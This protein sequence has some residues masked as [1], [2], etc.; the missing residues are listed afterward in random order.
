M[1]QPKAIGKGTVNYLLETSRLDYF[2]KGGNP[3]GKFLGSGADILFGQSERPVKHEELRA[4]LEGLH[5][6]TGASLVQKQ[7]DKDRQLG[8][9]VVV[10]PPK[11]L[12][13]LWSQLDE[14]R[15]R[16]LLEED[17]EAMKTTLRYVED[18]HIY[19]RRGKDGTRLERGKPVVAGFRHF[20]SRAGDPLIHTHLLISNLCFRA[21]GSTGTILSKPFYD[22]QKLFGAIYRAELAS[23]LEK[24]L[25]VRCT[26]AK[27]GWSFTFEGHSEALDQEF[28][29]RS[30]QINSKLRTHGSPA[31]REAAA[32]ETRTEKDE[33]PLGEKLAEWKKTGVAHG[34][35]PEQVMGRLPRVHSE[36]HRFA[37]AWK[38][39][40]RSVT[41]QKSHFTEHE[42]LEQVA[43]QAQGLGL[44]ANDFVGR[45]QRALANSRELIALGELKGFARYTTKSVFR[46]EQR[47]IRSVGKLNATRHGV[48]G[49]HILN[50]LRKYEDARSAVVSEVRHHVSQLINAAKKVPTEKIQR[51][52]LK[53]RSAWVPDVEQRQAI[54]ALTKKGSGIRALEGWAGT[55][56]TS[57][58]RVVNEIYQKRGYTVI[59]VT[60]AGKAAEELQAHSGIA[61]C[62]IETLKLKM[63]PTLAFQAK[64]HAKQIPDVLFGKI[65]SP[66]GV[67]PFKFTKKSVLVIDEVS[68]VETRDLTQLIRAAQRAGAM[69]I[70]AGDYRQLPAIGRG[71]GGEFIANQ[72]KKIVV[73]RIRRQQDERDREAIK[74]LGRGEA[75][76]ALKNLADRGKI[77][78][79]KNW[80]EAKA[81]LVADWMTR[82]KGNRKDAQIYVSG[83]EDRKDINQRC[84]AARLESGELKGH[85]AKCGE[86][87]FYQGDR[88]IFRENSRS[89]GVRNGKLGT[90]RGIL[91]TR[92]L[93]IA[94]VKLDSGKNVLVPLSSY[95][96][97]DHGYAVTA[98]VGQGGTNRNGYHLLGGG[99]GVAR[100]MGYVQLS[101]HKENI[102]IYTDRAHAGP[103][104]SRLAKML[105]QSR[106]K[107]LA[108]EVKRQVEEERGKV[109][110]HKSHSF[111]EELSL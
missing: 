89:I 15:Q 92:V 63:K 54:R 53:E 19:T 43:I 99:N 76:K 27:D 68:M 13:T 67:K 111:G 65:K 25:N 35:T 37:Q 64:Y 39:A 88:V 58:L 77:Q 83:N 100:E 7:K 61:S 110:L 48:G 86:N 93:P 1:W 78:V 108:H 44:G 106:K 14:E 36:S 34:Y 21:D 38:A 70:T 8:T 90:I 69:V 32:N 51:E 5:P 33:R 28:S 12:A 17:W 47:L 94:L 72:V 73:S 41:E 71:G 103:D 22:F 57:I 9:Q 62:T 98:H 11:S 29:K 105:S 49:I 23:R 74:D 31:A 30:K 80:D 59:G 16:W 46:T 107:T 6:K 104:L 101:R 96:R 66:K 24:R 26:L 75:G 82:E 3:P 4:I 109:H 40:L 50:T 2:L 85:A 55:G 84:Q 10:A 87:L 95:Q 79:E 20:Q 42:M 102:W 97:L 52:Q 60:T 18:H 45:F 56:K 81:K 91:G